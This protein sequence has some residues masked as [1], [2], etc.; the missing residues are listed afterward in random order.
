MQLSGTSVAAPVVAGAAALLLQA[1]PGLTPPLIKAI[2]QYTA[3]PLPGYNLIQQGAGMLNIEGAVRLA[4]ALRTDIGPA[5]AAG[6]LQTGDSLLAAGVSLPATQSAI[7][8]TTFNW[9]RLVMAGGTHLFSGDALFSKFQPFYDPTLTWARTVVL[10]TTVRYDALSANT[11]PRSFNE[12]RVTGNQP[13]I[14]GNVVLLDDIAN[15]N[16]DGL[17]VAT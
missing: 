8:G 10:R 12:V 15:A 9:G 1:N 3:Q 17:F 6:T 13:L 11:V 7:D 14:T 5:L 4:K 16:G 2:L